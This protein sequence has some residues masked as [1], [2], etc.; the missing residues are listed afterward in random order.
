MKRATNDR[1]QARLANN[2]LSTEDLAYIMQELYEDRDCTT[3]G[4]E[5]KEVCTNPDS[6][7][8]ADFV[9][10]SDICELWENK[11]EIEVNSVDVTLETTGVR[12]LTQDEF[13]G[14]KGSEY[15]IN[16]QFKTYLTKHVI[17]KYEETKT[18]GLWYRKNT[19][20]DCKVLALFKE[21]IVT[22]E[23]LVKATFSTC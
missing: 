18:I 23:Q 12:P 9:S 1:L 10:D 2:N 19:K 22:F 7:L 5:Y 21:D 17:D 6:R 15:W 20:I 8:C 11:D 14:L 13:N 4:W 16:E 3:C